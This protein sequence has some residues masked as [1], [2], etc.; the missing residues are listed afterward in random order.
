MLSIYNKNHIECIRS[1]VDIEEQCK[2]LFSKYASNLAFFNI[3]TLKE[4]FNCHR[5]FVN[6]ESL[7][8]RLYFSSFQFFLNEVCPNLTIRNYDKK[9]EH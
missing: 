6:A 5:I 4:S 1:N 7:R 3:Q 9:K 8:D 2:R